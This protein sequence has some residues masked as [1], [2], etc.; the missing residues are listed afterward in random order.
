MSTPVLVNNIVCY[1]CW[2]CAVLPVFA[3]PPR[4]VSLQ[5][6]EVIEIKQWKIVS[7]PTTRE[8]SPE[9]AGI[10]HWTPVSLL[11][12]HLQRLKTGIMQK[13]T[14]TLIQPGCLPILEIWKSPG[15]VSK[16]VKLL[17]K[18]R[19]NSNFDFP[20][21]HNMWHSVLGAF[22]FLRMSEH[23]HQEWSELNKDKE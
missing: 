6:A 18:D 12:L 19:E 13:D 10:G 16:N 21:H 8:M 1:R 4:N 17:P 9:A 5:A 20:Q 23:Q 7:T 2:R 3:S 15:I 14:S 22:C 11:L